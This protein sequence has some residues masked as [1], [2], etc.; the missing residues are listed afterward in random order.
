MP[1]Y[2]ITVKDTTEPP[3]HLIKTGSIR[4]Y[5]FDFNEYSCSTWQSTSTFISKQ[6]KKTKAARFSERVTV[7]PVHKG[8][9]KEL[10]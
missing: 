1:Y 10:R 9:R 2:L 4:N 5:S 8:Q 6:M 7:A 3:R